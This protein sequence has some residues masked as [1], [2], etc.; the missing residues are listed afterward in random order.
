MAELEIGASIQRIRDQRIHSKDEEMIA[1]SVSQSN[2]TDSWRVWIPAVLLA[3]ACG[4]TPAT[5]SEPSEA[6][7]HYRVLEWKDLVAEGW[8]R[9][10]LL[11]AEEVD[12]PRVDESS[13]VPELE[14]QLVALPGFMRPI[15][16]AGKHVTAGD[17]KHEELSEGEQVSEFLLV[18]FLPQHPCQHSLWD[19]NQVV[20][21]NLLEPVQV[22]DPDD[23]VWVVGT[24]TL[25]TV[26]TDDGLA[27]Y[28]IG[29]AVTTP[30]EY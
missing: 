23:P 6:Y 11:A 12:S 1:R 16:R 24:M 18:P 22:D 29:G 3:V 2:P 15:V 26:M 5:A 30:Y 25:E 17:H 28:R 14:H 9:P 7:E 13:L 20:H 10:L 21:V 4:H 27:A 19:P 8:E